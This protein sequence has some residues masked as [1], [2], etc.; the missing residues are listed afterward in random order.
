MCA[1]VTLSRNGDRSSATSAERVP[2]PVLVLRQSLFGWVGTGQAGSQ[3]GRCRWPVGVV[4]APYRI[5]HGKKSLR[6]ESRL[7]IRRDSPFFFPFPMNGGIEIQRKVSKFFISTFE[8][9]KKI[10][11]F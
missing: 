10:I 1:S 3:P 8:F 5:G 4:R 7:R 2:I 9:F 11:K 6:F